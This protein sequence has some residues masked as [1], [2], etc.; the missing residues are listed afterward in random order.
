MYR[1]I[2]VAIAMKVSEG[3]RQRLP[4]N[5]SFLSFGL[6]HYVGFKNRKY[7]ITRNFSVSAALYSIEDTLLVHRYR[8]IYRTRLTQTLDQTTIDTAF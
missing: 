1:L 4:L 6:V 8:T 2:F 7:R 5:S 3:S